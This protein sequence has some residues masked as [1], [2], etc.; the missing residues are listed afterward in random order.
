MGLNN[1]LGVT[2]MIHIINEDILFE[3]LTSA[4]FIQALL[5]FLT[6]NTEIK[7][8]DD[9]IDNFD[10]SKKQDYA[11][12][13]PIKDIKDDLLDFVNDWIKEVKDEC[14]IYKIEKIWNS[15]SYGF[16][17]YLQLSFNRPADRR[18]YPFYNDNENL[19][20]GVKFRFSEHESRND[21]SDIEQFVNLTGKPFNQAA[22][23]MKYLIQNYVT[24]LRSKEKQ[25]LKKLD[26]VSKKRR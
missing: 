8:A 10:K 22:E 18:L 7:Y 1:F 17:N 19:Y 9:Y 13:Y 2:F 23:E 11:K 14:D 16:S 21:D 25:Y 15:K 6:R 20:R 12:M 5:E 4:H 26:K 3:N 24:D